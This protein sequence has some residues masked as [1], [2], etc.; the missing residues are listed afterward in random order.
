[1]IVM[2]SSQIL[3]TAGFAAGDFAVL[4]RLCWVNRCSVALA[5]QTFGQTAMFTT[6]ALQ[7][8]ALAD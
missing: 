1:M 3:S 2:N 6:R 8:A 4:Q 5:G 7:V